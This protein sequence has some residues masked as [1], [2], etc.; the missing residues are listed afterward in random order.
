MQGFSV[1]SGVGVGSNL[2]KGVGSNLQNTLS[3]RVMY[4][5][6]CG[7]AVRPK[8]QAKVEKQS[9]IGSPP[10]RGQAFS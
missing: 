4:P 10:G 7:V 8:G 1:G 2:Q 9:D 3:L 5:M 6:R